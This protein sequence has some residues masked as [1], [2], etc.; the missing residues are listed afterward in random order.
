MWSLSRRGASSET[1]P[2]TSHRL[3]WGEP[4]L[5][6]DRQTWGMVDDHAELESP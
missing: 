1:D 5:L 4:R 6:D 3:G 2:L